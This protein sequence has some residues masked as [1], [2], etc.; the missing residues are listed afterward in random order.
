METGSLVNL[1]LFLVMLACTFLLIYR[2]AQSIRE[3]RASGRL[4][5]EGI[6]DL[7]FNPG[8]CL[9]ILGGL[10]LGVL[11]T[12]LMSILLGAF[13]SCDLFEA[14]RVIYWIRSLVA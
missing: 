11:I 9:L 1:V 2:L 5:F 7:D 4:P 6:Y 13:V 8:T 3:L 10:C 14:C 12:L